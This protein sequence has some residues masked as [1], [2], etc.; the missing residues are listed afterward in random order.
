MKEH[1]SG[2]PEAAVTVIHQ[3]L[4]IVAKYPGKEE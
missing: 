4:K 1:S 2:V 3:T